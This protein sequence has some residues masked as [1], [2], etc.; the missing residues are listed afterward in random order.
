MPTLPPARARARVLARSTKLHPPGFGCVELCATLNK[1]VSWNIFVL[2]LLT[3]QLATMSDEDETPQTTAAPSQSTPQLPVGTILE[4][5]Q[6]L[7]PYLPHLAARLAT[8]SSSVRKECSYIR[9]GRY[10]YFHEKLSA[11]ETLVP[12]GFDAFTRS[13]EHFGFNEDENGT[14]HFREWCPGALAVNII[15]DFS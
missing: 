11:F 3:R 4:N 8:H 7:E 1:S 14:I 9:V 2:C 5:D 10:A 12:G 6:Y 15:G 13:Y